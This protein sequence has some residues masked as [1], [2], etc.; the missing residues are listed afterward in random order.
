MSEHLSALE[1]AI[2]DIGRW[3]WWT[4]NLPA[5][6]QVEFGGTQL[7]NPP[8]GEGQPPSSRIALRFRKPRLVCFLTLVD[9]ASAD[10][11]DRLQRDEL[12]PP[13]VDHEA[14]TL[15]SAEL[16]GQLIRKAVA[17]RS[18]VGELGVTPLPAAGEALL[19]FEAGPFGLVVAAESLGVFN[20]HGEL[21]AGAVL[22][23]NRKWWEYWRE[24][25]RRRGTADPLPRD[26]ACEVTIPLA[27][28]TELN[29][30]QD[31]T[32]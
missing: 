3:T 30:A 32:A 26:F 22:A 10:W 18:L 12:E 27:S 8:P 11:P 13:S 1:S 29:V 28:G 17:V 23:S 5:A 19:G 9:D 14:F 31:P 25:W 15:T 6:F 24:Y 16:C 20:H 7:W 2:S 21:D 4:A